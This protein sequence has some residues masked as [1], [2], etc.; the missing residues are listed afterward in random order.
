MVEKTMVP[1]KTNQNPWLMVKPW[2]TI[3]YVVDVVKIR[4]SE[5][6]QAKVI[7]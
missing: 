3:K 1:P 7:K 2:S 5:T 6:V 4:L